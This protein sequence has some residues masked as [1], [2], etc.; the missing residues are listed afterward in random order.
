MTRV[1]IRPATTVA[2]GTVVGALVLAACGTDGA[3]PRPVSAEPDR[4]RSAK[5]APA[6][7]DP[8]APAQ[9]ATS[10]AASPTTAPDGPPF[11]DGAEPQVVEPEGE[12][13]LQLEDVRLG[14]HDG[15]DR[16]VLEFRGT[17]TPGWSVDHANRARAEGSGEVVALEGDRV[18]TI[19]ASGTAL[20]DAESYDVPQRLGPVGD[21]REVYVNGWFEGY[22]QVFAGIDGDR[23]AYRVFA[24]ADPPRLVVDVAE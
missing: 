8:T 4:T 21:I 18:L 12:W 19:A 13:D 11:V 2:L 23:P 14:E 9:P 5:P 1:T 6:P 3:D 10:A 24:L 15:F 16:I 22:T 17:G 20:P 7:T